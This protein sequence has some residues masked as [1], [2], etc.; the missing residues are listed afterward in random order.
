M[1]KAVDQMTERARQEGLRAGKSE[2]RLETLRND[3]KNVMEAFHVSLEEAMAGLKV[4][5]E[6]Q[7]L[8]KEMV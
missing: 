5:K 3:I 1:C 7:A 8:L 4:T 6:E 2:G